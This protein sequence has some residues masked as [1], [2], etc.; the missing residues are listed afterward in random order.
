MKVLLQ[1]IPFVRTSLDVTLL[2]NASSVKQ[3]VMKTLKML[4]ILL[5]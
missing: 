4:N 1:S 2:E 5:R 3:M